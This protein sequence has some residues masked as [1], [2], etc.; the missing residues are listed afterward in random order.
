MFVHNQIISA[1]DELISNGY[2]INKAIETVLVKK[3]YLFD[4]LFDES[5]NDDI[6]EDDEDNDTDEDNEDKDNDD[7]DDN[8]D[9]REDN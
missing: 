5:S 4:T 7:N 3:G 2:K 8:D 9:N 1:I 6:D